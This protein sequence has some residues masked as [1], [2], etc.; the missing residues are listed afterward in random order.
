MKSTIPMKSLFFVLEEKDIMGPSDVD[1]L[2][3][4]LDELKIKSPCLNVIEIYQKTRR[5]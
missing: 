4:A 3:E 2:T 5:K 1:R